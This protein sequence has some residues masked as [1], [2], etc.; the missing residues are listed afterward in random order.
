[1]SQTIKAGASNSVEVKAYVFYDGSQENVK[2]SNIT[3]LKNCNITLTFTA[4]PV[5]TQG[6]EVNV[7][8][9]AETTANGGN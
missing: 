8:N 5:N 7:T 2:T 1:M 3:N 9:E 6:S 4:T